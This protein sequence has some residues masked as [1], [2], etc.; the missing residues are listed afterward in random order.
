MLRYSLVLVAGFFVAGSLQAATWA[1]GLFDELSK[2]FGT[3]V[4]GPA[5]T[6]HFRVT[7]R[8]KY[9]VSIANV[10][11][12]C[13]CLSASALKT[14]L[15]PGEE[16]AIVARMDTTRFTGAKHVTVTVEFNM[17]NREEVRLWVQANGRDD[18]Q[19]TP[20]NLAFGHVRR[21]TSSSA[22][23]EVKFYGN[24]DARIL[25]LRAES[26]F[27]QPV[28]REISRS[29]TGE[30][31]Y[32]L[33]AELR[34]DIPVGK[35]FTDVWLKTNVAGMAQVRVP[36]TVE[37][38]SMLTINPGV[39]NLGMVRVNQENDRRIILRGAKPFKIVEIKGADAAVRVAYNDQEAREVHIL[40]IRCKQPAVGTVDRVLRVVTDLAEEKEVDFRVQSF[41]VE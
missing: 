17:P 28:A 4:R 11:V 9:A 19:I 40:T 41:A 14:F 22:A 15:N 20:E 27:I 32:Q 39:V 24:R 38:E 33:S 29:A 3:V 34:K 21:G 18:L 13:G 23:V 1:D 8:T 36:V 25:E 7:N 26:N 37:V 30:V 35:W 2:D 31:V 5:L 16:T 10:K 12:S 6:H